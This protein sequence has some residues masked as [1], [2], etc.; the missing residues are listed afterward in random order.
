[1]WRT[2]VHE[3]GCEDVMN[4]MDQNGVQIWAFV[5]SVMILLDLYQQIS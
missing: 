3:S 4:E 2:H 5:M 1:M